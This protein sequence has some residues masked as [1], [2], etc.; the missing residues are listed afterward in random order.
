[1][2][3]SMVSISRPFL[4]ASSGPTWRAA[5]MSISCDV[6]GIARPAAERFCAWPAQG[7]APRLVSNRLVDRTRLRRRSGSVHGVDVRLI[8]RAA[9]VGRSS[10][11]SLRRFRPRMQ[12]ST[13]TPMRIDDKLT[14]PT[15]S[16][17][18]S[19]RQVVGLASRVDVSARYRVDK[20]CSVANGYNVAAI[21]TSRR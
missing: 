3:S 9:S 5:D 6:A 2:S 18:D 11:A 1:M 14:V 21:G 4:S 7:W 17:A 8:P 12:F 16:I 15:T 19:P 10:A 20:A 13:V